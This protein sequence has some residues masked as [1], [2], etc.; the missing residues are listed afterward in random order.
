MLECVARIRDNVCKL[1]LLCVLVHNNT[2]VLTMSPYYSVHLHLPHLILKTLK[3]Y[4]FFKKNNSDHMPY[5]LTKVVPFVALGL[6]FLIRKMTFIM[7]DLK[8]S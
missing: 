4:Y 5:S 2:T 3:K 1:S 6:Y 8:S 7:S